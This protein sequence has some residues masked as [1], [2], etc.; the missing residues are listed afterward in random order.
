MSESKSKPLLEVNDLKVHF[1]INQSLLAKLRKQDAK[2]V[3]AVDGVSFSIPAGKSFG[4]VGESGSGKTTTALAIMRLLE[5][6]SGQVTL[7]GDSI[8][9]A[10]GE[11]LRNLRRGFQMVFQD[12]FAS[13]NP[14]KRVGDIVKSA[15]NLMKIGEPASRDQKVAE[16]FK[17]VG[18]S[19][20]QRLLFPHQFSGG[21]RQRI[22]IA[23]ALAA[24]PKLL[25][26][27]EPVSALDVAIQAQIL[28]LL[29]KLRKHLGLTILFISH[30]L[31]V[32]R[33]IC[34]DVAVM[35]LGVIVEQGPAQEVF[36]NPLHPYTNALMSAL[37]SFDPRQR[38]RSNRVRLT[39]DP[40]SPIDLPSGCRFANRCPSAIEACRQA[41]PALKE[42]KPG[43]WVRCSRLELVDHQG[44]APQWKI[45]Q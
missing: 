35:Y 38:G 42:I 31:G 13:L 17:A 16:L 41:E 23:R 18:L 36:D 33:H 29:M 25:V 2:K 34:D 45:P 1:A 4:I 28:N 27:D 15:L 3:K 14:R 21:Q 37:P 7:D 9:S 5:L 32:V 39:G 8:S 44:T 22:V 43:R 12:P 30:D 6:S 40:P 24:E 19:P 26:C 11:V 10:Q 20:E